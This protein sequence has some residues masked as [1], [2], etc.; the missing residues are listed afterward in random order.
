M[1]RVNRYVGCNRGLKANE[2]AISKMS[3]IEIGTEIL[4]LVSSTAFVV[5][6][7]W[8]YRRLQKEAAEAD[9]SKDPEPKDDEE[10]SKQS[11]I[12]EGDGHE[13]EDRAG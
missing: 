2:R 10:Q 9:S 1:N 8:Y 4:I 5:W 11:R 6:F 3:E 7:V 12:T 13:Q